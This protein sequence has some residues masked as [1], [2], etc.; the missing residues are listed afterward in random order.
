MLRKRT[1]KVTKV[2]EVPINV[3]QKRYQL[4]D[5]IGVLKAATRTVHHHKKGWLKDDLLATGHLDGTK[6]ALHAKV[7]SDYNAQKLYVRA[8]Q[9]ILGDDYDPNSKL[10]TFPV[11]GYTDT[12]NLWGDQPFYI[13][14]VP[15]AVVVQ[16][17]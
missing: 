11:P 15:G 14:R 10:E 12:E 13:L 16:G 6:A 4:S 1:Q 9:D 8:Q 7:W 17:S 5:P 2:D 3:N